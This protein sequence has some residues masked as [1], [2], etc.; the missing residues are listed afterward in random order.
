MG[1][2]YAIPDPPPLPDI[3][4]C[5][6]DL[7]SVTG[8]DFTGAMYVGQLNTEAKVYICVLICATSR[9]IHHKLVTDLSVETFLLAFRRFTSC[10]S[11]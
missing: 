2:P 8:I 4:T 9:A 11:L 1:Q 3:G 6:S 7:F 5:Q 10:R